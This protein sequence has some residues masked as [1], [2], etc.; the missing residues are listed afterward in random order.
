MTA[1]YIL[2][3]FTEYIDRPCHPAIELC[4][5]S[6]HPVPHLCRT[7]FILRDHVYSLVRTTFILRVNVKCNASSLR[8]QCIVSQHRISSSGVGLL[9]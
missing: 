8:I 4:A 6:R 1:V 3:T 7:T 5:S 2:F 9:R